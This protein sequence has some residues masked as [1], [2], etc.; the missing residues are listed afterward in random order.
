MLLQHRLIV[1]YWVIGNG[2]GLLV[3][4]HEYLYYAHSLANV[5]QAKVLFRPET[6]KE[7]T[8]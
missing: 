8:P 2:K 1:F 4:T 3:G 7:N 6:Q 5:L